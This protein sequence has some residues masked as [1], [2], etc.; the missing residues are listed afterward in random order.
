MISVLSFSKSGE[1]IAQ[2]IINVNADA[3]LYKSSEG[4]IRD[5]MEEIW[6]NSDA[7]IFISATGIAVRYIAPFIKHKSVD[8]AVLVIDDMGR[9]VIS[10]LSGHLGGANYMATEIAG[11]LKESIA[12]ITTASDSRGFESLDLYAKRREFKILKSENLTAVSSAM[13]DGRELA[14][15]SEIDPDLDYGNIVLIG[16]EELFKD[17]N[18]V[19]IAI[20]SE[21][22]DLS[23]LSLQLIPKIL[24]LGIGCRRGVKSKVII[25]LIEEVFE[26]HGL[27]TDAIAGI[28]SIELKSDET[29]ILE[30]AEYFNVQPRFYSAEEIQTVEGE[31]KG[32]EFVRKITG[33]GA[34]AEPSAFLS[35]G[36]ILVERVAKNDVTI[37]VA[38]KR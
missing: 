33:V 25:E 32:S 27:Y 6:N 18:R 7:I 10:L 31:F 19:K 16:K 38:I 17:E 11:Y 2:K 22:L 21:V 9:Y 5:K 14:V 12:I 24:Y 3:V 8:P 23:K 28:S 13:V 20:S 26:K 34:V 30:A 29:G 1:E 35:G 4:K 36:E 15:Y 37:A